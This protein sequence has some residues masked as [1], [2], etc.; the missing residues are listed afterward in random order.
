MIGTQRVASG[1]RSRSP[2]DRRCANYDGQGSS[3]GSAPRTSRTWLSSP[4][5]PPDRQIQAD[6]Q[7]VEALGS[8]LMVHMAIDATTVNSG[9][10]DAPDELPGE[11]A[12]NLVARF[13]PRSQVHIDDHVDVVVATENIHFFD[14]ET[15]EVIWS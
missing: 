12:A 3:S 8:E 9:D 2:S 15:H 13:S 4:N 7:L 14:A 1:S 6:R 10:P 5:A 11:G